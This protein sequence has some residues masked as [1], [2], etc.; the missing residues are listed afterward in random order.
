MELECIR[1]RTNSVAE[2]ALPRPGVLILSDMR[3]LRESLAKVLGADPGWSISGACGDLGDAL[4]IIGRMPPDVVLVD[5]MVPEGTRAVGLIRSAGP[6]ARVAVFNVSE[7][8]ESIVGWAEAG[9][10]GYVP[11]TAALSDVARILGEIM[12]GEQACSARVA[13]SLLRRLA[14]VA[15][16]GSGQSDAPPAV[17]LTRREREIVLLIGTGLS[18]KEIARH[19]NI[20]VATTKS[21]VHN[22][23]TKL[24]LQ[25]RAQVA[26]WMREHGRV[27]EMPHLR[28]PQYASRPV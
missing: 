14:S 22:L 4:D 18:N 16:S 5:A 24:G 23:L 3:L 8:E 2:G 21:H 7:M 1:R 6:E 27:F 10:A 19:L 15:R 26:H 11:K 20:G 13:G 12:H 9:A 17:M 25:R 28:S